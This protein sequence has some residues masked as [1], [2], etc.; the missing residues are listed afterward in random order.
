M[1]GSLKAAD[2]MAGFLDVLASSIPKLLDQASPSE[3]LLV[4]NKGVDLPFV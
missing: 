3:L 2:H 1:E 4:K